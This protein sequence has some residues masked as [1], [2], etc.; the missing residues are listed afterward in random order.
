LSKRNDPTPPPA[1]RPSESAK[2]EPVHEVSAV[3]LAEYAGVYYSEELDT[4]FRIEIENGKLAVKHARLP[5][6]YFVPRERDGFYAGPAR[7]LFAHDSLGRVTGMGFSAGRV[8]NLFFE[9]Q[10]PASEIRPLKP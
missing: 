10:D 7:I 9:R 1:A 8:R 2:I 3:E 5:T 6:V 4:S